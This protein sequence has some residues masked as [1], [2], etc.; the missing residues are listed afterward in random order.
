M[1]SIFPRLTVSLLPVILLAACNLPQGVVTETDTGNLATKVVLTLAAMTQ[2]AQLM[3]SSSPSSPTLVE[4]ATTQMSTFTVTSVPTYTQVP[5][6]APTETP[7]PTNTPLSAPG[8]IAGGISGYPYGSLPS[9]AIVAY[10]QEPPYNYS[11][12]ITGAGVAYF[13]MST[14]YL[15]PGHYQVVAYDSSSR[16]GGCTFNVLVISN[17]IVN[18][19]ITNWG[20]SYRAKPSGVP[21]P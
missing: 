16:A 14:D 13:S 5:T 10:G 3:P 9:L 19:D 20:G 15:I 11:Y 4:P 6:Q 12:M 7:G 1:K 21:S 8:T 18:C 2:P 17:E